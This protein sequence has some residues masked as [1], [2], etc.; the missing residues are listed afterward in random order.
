MQ[1]ELVGMRR[2]RVFRPVLAGPFALLSLALAPFPLG[3]GPLWAAVL[4]LVNAAPWLL[5]WR[6]ARRGHSVWRLSAAGLEQRD[7][8]GRPRRRYP[9]ADIGELVVAA[10]TGMLTVTDAFGARMF[11]ASLRSMGLDLVPLWMTARALDVTIEV[12][13]SDPDLVDVAGRLPHGH[14]EETHRRLLALEAALLTAAHTAP[15]AP[16]EPPRVTSAYARR[17]D[18][19]RRLGLYAARGL[20][21]AAALSGLWLTA[22]TT[23]YRDLPDRALGGAAAVLSGFALASLTRVRRETAAVRWTVHG[24]EL[25]VRQDTVGQWRVPLAAIAAVAPYRGTVVEPRTGAA[26]SGLVAYVFGHDT[27]IL[28][29]L[30]YGA[31]SP[32][33]VAAALRQHGVRLVDQDAA[34]RQRVA[35]GGTPGGLFGNQVLPRLFRVLPGG[36]LLVDADGLH[37]ADVAAGERLTVPAARIGSIEL[38]TSHG[39]AWLRLRDDE[40]DVV[41]HAPLA[42]LRASRTD[43]R[44]GARR[45]GLPVVDREYDA[46]TEAAFAE[47]VRGYGEPPAAAEPAQRLADASGVAS[48]A[49][50]GARRRGA[51]P[52]PGYRMD[53]EGRA[54][55]G[56][57]AGRGGAGRQVVIDPSPRSRLVGYL[58]LP[59][60]LGV[61]GGLTA[62]NLRVVVGSRL[63]L[64]LVVAASLLIGLVAA[65]RRS[66]A[67]PR[68]AISGRGIAGVSRGGRVLWRHDRAALGG[69]EVDESGRGAHLVVWSPGAREL[70]R[71][72]V[73]VSPGR[74]RSACEGYGLP[75]GPPAPPRLVGPP[76]EQ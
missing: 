12:F 42:A 62:S 27:Q 59:A 71:Q 61:I 68:L 66:R 28:G 70:W 55:R 6:Q 18:A 45:A 13:D 10:D 41:L 30:P 33:R 67:R 2:R 54:G 37:W 22:S 73:D 26:S 60:G 50:G 75:W 21:A 56:H 63:V 74:L 16:A 9:L 53:G 3:P 19:P 49:K 5:G 65:V 8:A 76:P 57:L 34:P 47:L 24:D 31:L 52:G 32:E 48:F 4:L 35:S 69:V 29:A 44:E 36:R 46:Y 39:H 14:N 11:A 72:P 7:A 64:A 25:R 1:R 23:Q 17:S 58:C 38:R 40:G 51:P 20:I 43:V 15:A